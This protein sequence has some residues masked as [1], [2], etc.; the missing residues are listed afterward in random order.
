LER[1]RA[2]KLARVVQ[3]AD[4]RVPKHRHVL[5]EVFELKA[6]E[7]AVLCVLLLRGPQTVGELRGRTE[8][9]Y[10]FS[11]LAYVEGTLQ[12]LSERA[13]VPLVMRLP[14]LAGQKEA[15]YAHLL[16]GPVELTEPP[17]RPAR[18]DAMGTG[19]DRVAQLESEV[20]TLRQEL[21]ELRQQFTEFKKQFE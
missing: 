21:V 18:R 10:S 7:M 13:D 4:G 19:D 12:A 9:L 6:A 2:K 16:S 8:R 3:T 5:N 1:L 17:P 20:T 15:R 14:R 11:D